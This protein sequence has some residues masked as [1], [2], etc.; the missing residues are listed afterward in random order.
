MGV[1]S[2]ALHSGLDVVSALIAFFT[3]RAAVRPA[4]RDHPFGHGKIETLSSLF[5][6][7]LLVVAAAWIFFEALEHV[8]QPQPVL[9]QNLAI[10]TILV[11]AL[12]SFFMY[13][14]NSLAATQSESSAIQANSLHFLADAVSS[15]GILVGLLLLKFTGWLI[16]DPV[17]A[18]LVALY[19]LAISIP[20]IKR[21][22]FELA[23]VQLPVDE[24]VRIESLVNEYK[25][26]FIDFHDL[27]TRKSGS[28]RHIDFHLTVCGRLSVHQSHTLC[29]EIETSLLR[30]FQNASINIHVEPCDPK[31]HMC[32]N[33]NEL[34][35]S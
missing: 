14:H 23:D 25:N 15:C 22:L 19:I 31:Q 12:V 32:K 28:I 30:S 8:R 26:Q 27:R 29:D 33:T 16:I 21:A 34:L 24:V 17:I 2:E 7:L 4:D 10:W 3:V 6:S 11:S 18:L 5:E 13:R 35:T 1:L 20:Q 9:H